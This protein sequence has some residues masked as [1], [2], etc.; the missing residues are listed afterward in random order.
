RFDEAGRRIPYHGV[1]ERHNA[2]IVLSAEVGYE[3]GV[4]MLG[5]KYFQSGDDRA[6]VGV[7][8]RIGEQQ[9][10]SASLQGGQQRLGLGASDIGLQRG[11][12]PRHEQASLGQLPSEALGQLRPRQ[13][14]KVSQIVQSGRSGDGHA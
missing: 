13:Q 10:T 5:H 3:L 14:R 6:P 1:G 11:R 4:G 2:E 9:R 12:V 7:G 8:S